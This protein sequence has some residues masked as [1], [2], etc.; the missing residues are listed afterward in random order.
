MSLCCVCVVFTTVVCCYVFYNSRNVVLI[1]FV[2][3]N[4]AYSNITVTS[5]CPDG[6]IGSLGVQINFRYKDVSVWPVD[7]MCCADAEM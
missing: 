5:I 4:Y 3:Q 7:R 1:Q 2:K 6:A